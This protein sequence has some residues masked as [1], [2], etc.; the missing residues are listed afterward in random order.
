MLA[1]RNLFLFSIVAVAFK[2]Y[3]GVVAQADCARF[4]TVSSGDTCD[5][6]S[7]KKNVSTFQLATVNK[8]IIDP[9]C[10]NLAVDEV[11]CLGITGQDCNV[12]DIVQSGDSCAVITAAAGVPLSTLLAN[13]P[14]INTDCSNIYPGEV[15]CTS[16]QAFDYGT[17]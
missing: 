2:L 16:T 3:G 15:L 4:Y 11:I 14:N 13:N 6:I 8:A 12:T 10:D 1:T 7:A 17:A 9:A 5:A